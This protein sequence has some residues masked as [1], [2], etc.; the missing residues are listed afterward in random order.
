M[1][2]AGGGIRGLGLSLGVGAVAILG[3]NSQKRSL[4]VG[5]MSGV[6]VSAKPLTD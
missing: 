5:V 4:R 1:F 6:S 2:G 3:D